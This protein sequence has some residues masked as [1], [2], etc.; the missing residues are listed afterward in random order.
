MGEFF[1]N[2]ID[3]DGMKGGLDL[4]TA[5]QLGALHVPVIICGGVGEASHVVDGLEIAGVDAVAATNYFHHVENSIQLARQSAL[6][7]GILVRGFI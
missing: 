6:S 5:S 7:A 2:S 4:E 3:R 1:L